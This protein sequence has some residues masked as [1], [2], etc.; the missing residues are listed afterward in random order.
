MRHRRRDDQLAL[1]FA[2]DGGAKA[3]FLIRQLF[4]T[5]F[6]IEGKGKSRKV[7]V[8]ILLVIG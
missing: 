4:R 5:A 1:V 2:V 7:R 3:V 8:S 6:L